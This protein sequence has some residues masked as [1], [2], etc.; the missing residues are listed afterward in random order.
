MKNKL[1]TI[2]PQEWTRIILLAGLCLVL[3]F[4]NLNRW[5][6]WNPDEPRYAQ[7]AREMVQRG[8]W[9]LMHYN[10]SVYD[11]KPPLFFWL[12]ALSSYLWQGFSSFT[13]RFP[14]ALFGTLTVIL[15]FF[16]GKLLYSSRTGFLSALVLATSFEFVYLSTRANIDTTL[17]FFTTASL[18]CFF[19]W[20]RDRKEEEDKKLN[21]EAQAKTNEKVEAQVNQKKRNW[22]IYGFYTGMALA[23]LAIGP[24]GI[25]LPL[26]VG[27]IFLAVQKDWKAMR[28]MKLLPGVLLFI[29]I[30]LSWYVP[31]V[32]KGGREYF[33]ATLLHHSAARFAQGTSHIRPFYYFFYNFPLHFLPWTFLLPAAVAYGFSQE[34]LEKRKEFLYLLVWSVVIFSFFSISKGK[35]ILY[36]LPLFPAVSLMVGKLSEDLIAGPMEHFKHE[37]ISIPLYGLAGV[38]LAAAGG[39]LWGVYSR[40]PVFAVYIVPV[41]VLLA[42]LGAAL[43]VLSRL[44]RH[45]VILLV[46]VCVTGA[47]FFYTF[48]VGFP[49]IN[50]LK[51]GRY[52]SQEIA[53]RIQPGEK[54]AVYGIADTGI[55]NYHT[56]IVPILELERLEALMAFMQS[57]ERVYCL[58]WQNVL[59]QYQSIPGWPVPEVICRQGVGHRDIVL[60]SNRKDQR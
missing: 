36:L 4:F 26:L 38:A 54:V 42:G 34:T 24:I 60:I 1:S 35:R 46:L 20:Y 6:L 49:L 30:V 50:P 45:A 41:A 21:V 29:V 52:I 23:T 48:R 2:Y 18:F 47:G 7:V 15:T 44:R 27:L 59:E 56:G 43:W 33:E 22:P 16:F 8:D 55:Y 9:I 57:K 39:V 40:F 14:A 58:L 5:D 37:W 13:A 10:G 31:A 11:D 12:I 32:L 53:S 19:K 17:T 3:Y 25:L 51:S 28:R